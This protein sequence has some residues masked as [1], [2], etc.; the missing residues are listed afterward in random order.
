M[1]MDVYG[2]NPISEEGQ[3]FRR[4]VWHWRRLAELVVV[5]EPELASKNKYWQSNDGGGLNSADSKKMA[6]RLDK[7]VAD[8]TVKKL[9]DDWDKMLAA[10]PRVR[11]A[12]CNGT[13]IRTDEIGEKSRMEDKIVEVGP[14]D[15]DQDNPRKGLKGWCNG[16]NGYGSRK[17]DRTMYS[18]EVDDVTEFAKFMRA[19]GGFQIC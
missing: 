1:G 11:C 17:D 18:V 16:C 12:L 6:D 4:N 10:L 5:L 9:I 13:G 7:H 15:E 2:K 8:G 14:D 19:S 3:Y